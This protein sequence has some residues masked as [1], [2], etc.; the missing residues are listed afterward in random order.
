[1]GIGKM[2]LPKVVGTKDI[3]LMVKQKGILKLIGGVLIKYITIIMQDKKP[4]DEKQRG[5]GQWVGYHKDGRLQF[6]THYI[7]GKN[8]GSRQWFNYKNNYKSINEYYAR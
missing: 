4:R 8:Y 2:Y 7:H 1:M 5:H 3:L 6:K